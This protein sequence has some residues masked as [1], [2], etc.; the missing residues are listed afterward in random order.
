[1]SPYIE[2]PR[3]G[4]GQVASYRI[5]ATGDTLQVCDECDAVWPTGV[6]PVNAGFANLEDELSA[7]GL[8]PGWEQLVEVEWP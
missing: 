5:A 2:C 6:E 1:M 4:Q 8:P 3:C 7:R